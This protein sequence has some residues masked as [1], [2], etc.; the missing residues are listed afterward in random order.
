MRAERALPPG[1]DDRPFDIVFLDRDGTINLRVDR[2]VTSPADLELLPG[3]GEAIAAIN[4]AGSRV[5]ILTNQRGLATGEL[6]EIQLEDVHRALELE[7]ARHGAHVDAIFVCPHEDGSCDCRKPSPGLFLAA[8]RAAPWADPARCVMVGDAA[9]D[10][11]PALCLGLRAV[12][13]GGGTADPS[14]EV[15]PSLAVAVQSLLGATNAAVSEGSG[16]C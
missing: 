2:Y 10:I 6:S 9:G 3:A 1:R 5:V 14:W 12:F 15:A 16:R 8:F 11:V 13:V 4:R 7:L